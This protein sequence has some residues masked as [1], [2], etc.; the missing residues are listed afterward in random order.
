MKSRTLNQAIE[1]SRAGLLSCQDP[2]TLDVPVRREKNR[3]L[4]KK[5]KQS[6]S[7]V[8]V[9]LGELGRQAKYVSDFL[10]AHNIRTL[11]QFLSRW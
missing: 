8:D 4:D 10:F 9:E 6:L 2:T 7:S 11:F 1:F 3:T 5:L